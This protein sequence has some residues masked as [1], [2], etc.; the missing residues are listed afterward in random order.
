[1]AIYAQEPSTKRSSS[2]KEMKA[3]SPTKCTSLNKHKCGE[4][5]SVNCD[6]NITRDT[7]YESPQNEN[8]TKNK[9]NER[10][11]AVIVLCAICS[12]QALNS[13]GDGL[14]GI[15]VLTFTR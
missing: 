4:V 1:M 12:L 2:S 6:E 11:E 7:E 8:G 3:E 5:M 10:L 9:F 15:I 14:I 13:V